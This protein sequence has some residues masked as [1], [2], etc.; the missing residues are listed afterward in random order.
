M[1]AAGAVDAKNASTAPWK[2]AKNAVSHTYHRPLFVTGAP[3]KSVTH[4]PGGER[5]GSCRR[6]HAVSGS[7]WLGSGL[8]TTVP[9]G[10]QF[11]MLRGQRSGVRL[12]AC[13]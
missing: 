4:V 5:Q 1:E 9:T 12:R 10:V 6:R 7:W 8:S 11:R 3:N 2:T 13:S